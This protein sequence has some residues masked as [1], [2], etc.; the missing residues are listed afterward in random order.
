MALKF[1][2]FGMLDF[3]CERR[4]TRAKKKM[5]KDLQM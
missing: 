5:L 1:E 4:I 2:T 3:T